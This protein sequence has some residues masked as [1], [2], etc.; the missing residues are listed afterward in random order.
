LNAQQATFEFEQTRLEVERMK[1]NTP[2]QEQVE[3]YRA[4]LEKEQEI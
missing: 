3:Q 1:L 4:L 2:V